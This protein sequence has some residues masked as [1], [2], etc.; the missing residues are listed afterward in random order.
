MADYGGPL[1]NSERKNSRLEGMA[2]PK[3]TE[4]NSRLEG[5][6]P[7]KQTEINSAE[8][9]GKEQFVIDFKDG[10]R[11]TALQIKQMFN[12][13][14]TAPETFVGSVTSRMITDY[15]KKNNPTKNQ[16][17]EHFSSIDLNRGGAIPMNNQMELF[18]RG[19]LKDE[20]GT[21]D[22][23]SGNEVPV[24]GIKKGV[25]DD[26]PV[27]VSEG[28]FIF[29]E[30]VT[31]YIG[32]DKLM[33]IRQD[34][35]MG[36][37][38]MEAMGQMG[39]SDEATMDDDMPF[40]MADLVVVGGRGEP[41]EF[42]D[43]G[44]VSTQNF[45]EGGTPKKL[46]FQ[47]LMG[48]GYREIK[49]YRNAE[50]TRLLVIFI[51]GVPIHPIPPGYTLYVAPV[52]GE[53]EGE[54]PLD[55]ADAEIVA[56]FNNSNDD[57]DSRPPPKLQ[58]P[59]NWDTIS[60]DKFI[61]KANELTGTGR[62]VANVV[63]FFMGPLGF[64]AKGLLMHQDKV[65]ADAIE[66]R[67][68]NGD[69]TD[70]QIA[71]L[72]VIS[73]S[74]AKSGS[75][76]FGSLIAS[77]GNIFG[78]SEAEIKKVEKDNGPDGILTSEDADQNDVEITSGGSVILSDAAKKK[79]MDAGKDD[80]SGLDLLAEENAAK[81]QAEKSDNAL[82]NKINSTSTGRD[83]GS[84]ES[85]VSGM[86]AVPA[87][88]TNI[89]SDTD[90]GKFSGSP[91]ASTITG[92]TTSAFPSGRLG[93]DIPPASISNAFGTTALDSVNFD[94]PSDVGSPSDIY[95]SLPKSQ[96]TIAKTNRATTAPVVTTDTLGAQRINNNLI[97]VA[98]S[99]EP[100]T[101]VKEP[102]ILEKAM[103]NLSNRYDSSLDF[104]SDTV[105]NIVDKIPGRSIDATGKPIGSTA[106]TD[107]M[108]AGRGSSSNRNNN[109][110]NVTPTRA[111]A[112][113]RAKINTASDRLD[114]ATGPAGQST[115]RKDAGITFKKSNND[116]GFT[117]GFNKGGLAS[118]PKAKKIKT[119]NKRGLA[120]RK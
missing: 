33:Q 91:S 28:E 62:T 97:P 37:K 81:A 48:D 4:K 94:K 56:A 115:V 8:Y 89:V 111:S 93:V 82:I 101:K 117:G 105:S 99:G 73:T 45:Q 107:N 52:D 102:S 26:M 67:I 27:N 20:G 84:A 95:A 103:S 42:A 79:Y 39:N 29:P 50:G 69:F 78:K 53:P 35:K 13:S 38:K 30:D 46:T 5:M 80:K 116:R 90:L 88:S 3:Q 68:A 119:T 2:P 1:K 24:G 66:K 60:A 92:Q 14:G 16:F 114:Q 36:L 19:G 32:L 34:A 65:V 40:E 44:F 9:D 7:P 108:L 11:L 85:I 54:V 113:T 22:E 96:T 70:S 63:T 51:G 15:I 74:L 10:K 72:E 6:A 58:E 47:D 12:E 106:E 71:Q 110:N 43:G 86:N 120:A 31:R 17:I 57:N 59:V 64:L 83:I 87:A 18:S 25:R 109:N 23:V 41:M 55:P 21:I 49:E 76:I 104:I 77:I 75:G 118:K 112:A 100:I 61:K 98:S